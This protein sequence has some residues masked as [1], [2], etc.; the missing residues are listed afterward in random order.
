LPAKG[1]FVHDP[2]VGVSEQD[3][4]A[5]DVQF[6]VHVQ[7]TAGAVLPG[8]LVGP[9]EQESPGRDRRAL[10][11][12]REG[13]VLAGVTQGVAGQIDGGGAGVVEFKPILVTEVRQVGR[14]DQRVPVA[15]HPLVDADAR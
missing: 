12:D 4:V 11:D 7:V 14:V 9:H 8:L 5:V 1:H 3:A 2:S 15:R 6:E 13:Q 10:R